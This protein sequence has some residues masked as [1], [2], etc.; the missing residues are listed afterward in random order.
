[1]VNSSQENKKYSQFLHWGC[2]EGLDCRSPRDSQRH[3]SPRLGT[4]AWGSRQTL[5]ISMWSSSVFWKDSQSVI[6]IPFTFQ[7]LFTFQELTTFTINCSTIL[8]GTQQSQT[9]KTLA[10]LWLYKGT[11]L[12]LPPSCNSSPPLQ[13]EKP[14]GQHRDKSPFSRVIYL[15]QNLQT[16]LDS[17]SL[18]NGDIVDYWKCL[19][20]YWLQ[21]S[22]TL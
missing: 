11:D 12:L 2:V 7:L 18:Q 3:R 13:L 8:F 10:G 20:N 21:K 15:L 17:V 4:L 9:K 19:Q 22:L 16:I 5:V 1:M 14:E 6:H